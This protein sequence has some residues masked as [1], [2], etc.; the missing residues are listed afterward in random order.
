MKNNQMDRTHIMQIALLVVVNLF[1][2]GMVGLERTVVPLMAEQEF[3][4]IGKSAALSFII[5][6]GVVKAITNLFAGRIADAIGR[7][8]LLVAGW[9]FGLP[10]PFL[11]MFAPTWSWII[12]ANVLLG[13]NQGVTWSMTVNMKIVWAGPKN[14]GLVVGLNEFAGYFALSVTAFLSGYIAA[15]YGVRPQP[16]YLG[17]GY[18]LLGLVF[19]IFLVKNSPTVAPASSSTFSLAQSFL[20]TSW[21]NKQLF[22][23][24]QAGFIT[25][26]KDGMTWGL[27]PLFL[28]AQGLSL[29]LTGTIVAVYPATMALFQLVSGPLSDKIGRKW[30]ITVGMFLQGLAT[31]WIVSTHAFIEWLGG[32]MLLGFGTAL[33]YPVLIAAISDVAEPQWRASA[34]GVYRFWRDFGYAAGALVAG[35]LADWFGI[36][37]SVTSIG[38]IMLLSGIIVLTV[39]RETHKRL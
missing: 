34:L 28:T 4:I 21:K 17:V 10:I 33:V 30:L 39:L 25:N 23:A 6:F 18:A 2:G 35:V 8:R 22:S 1:V 12:F 7:K 38:F 13:I 32:A 27:F 11:V 31:I 19:S 37:T 5:S 24:T 20:E 16:F 15:H 9:L 26:F 29:Q 14:R 3:G 36:V